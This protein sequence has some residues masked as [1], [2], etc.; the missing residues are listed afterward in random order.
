MDISRIMTYAE[1]IEGEKL[2]ERKV[3]EFKRARLAGQGSS[4]ASGQEFDKDKV[5]NPKA[6]DGGVSGSILSKC[7]RNHGGKCLFGMG[8]CFGYGKMG[9][10]ISECPNKEREG[11]PQGQATQGGQA[12][13]GG[14]QCQNRFYVLQVRQDVEESLDMVTGMLWVF[15]FD[16]Y[17]LL[18]LGFVLSFVNPYLDI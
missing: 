6:Q 4:Q 18:D 10:K 12:Q 13:Q 8:T 14:G 15:D 5:S 7:G 1:L 11:R 3:R 2:E 17:T 16:V 9:H